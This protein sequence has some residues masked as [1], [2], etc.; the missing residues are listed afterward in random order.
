MAWDSSKGFWA[1]VGGGIADNTVEKIPGWDS[2][3]GFWENTAG[4][5]A[6]NTVEKIPGWDDSKGV[7]ANVAGG[8]QDVLGQIPKAF[9]GLGS[10]AVPLLIGAAVVLLLRKK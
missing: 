7:F 8:T 4:G 1:N 6:D 10:V 2:S 9:S 5:I 3:K